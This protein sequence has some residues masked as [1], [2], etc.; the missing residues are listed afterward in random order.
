ML[1]QIVFVFCMLLTFVSC[2]TYMV[3]DAVKSDNTSNFVENN[4]F[5]DTE[6]DYVYKASIQVYGN[7]LGGVFIIKKIS[8]YEHRV[9]FTTE[10]GNRLFDFQVSPTTNKVN[11]VIEDL[12]KKIIKNTLI[13][14]FRILLEQ[15]YLVDQTYETADSFIY[16]N[17]DGK[18]NHFLFVNQS[19]L[20]LTKISTTSKTKEK[21]NFTFDAKNST[22]AQSIQIKHN[23]IK[24][25]ISMNYIGN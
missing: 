10:F 18:R 14:D 23:N 11:Y 12:D 1:R 15:K 16:K 21:V 24:L 2:Q 22:F 7:Q 4:Y 19:D 25:T 8:E 6:K 20:L 9:V 17:K 13:S 3:K 5:L